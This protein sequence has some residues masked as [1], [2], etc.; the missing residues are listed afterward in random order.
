[1][2]TDKLIVRLCMGSSCYTRGNSE[3]LEVIKSYISEHKLQ[4]SIDFRGHLC[5]G[6]CNKGPNL[7]VG[8][9]TYNNVNLSNVTMILDD[10]LIEK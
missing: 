2:R 6:H 4:D 3:V 9:T 10:L 7:K 1:M 5:N 8:D